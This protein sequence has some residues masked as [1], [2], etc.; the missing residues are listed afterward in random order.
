MFTWGNIVTIPKGFRPP[1][2]H[3]LRIAKCG[4][5]KNFTYNILGK[6]AID[7]MSYDNLI[8]S[9]YVL[10]KCSLGRLFG[11]TFG[12][13]GIGGVPCCSLPQGGGAR[14]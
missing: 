10:K 11:G 14:F 12:T 3:P 8:L 4:S 2:P 6:L 13:F 7:L 5:E 9:K 1:V